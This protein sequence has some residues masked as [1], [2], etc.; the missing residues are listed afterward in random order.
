MPGLATGV[1]RKPSPSFSTLIGMGVTTA[2]CVAVGVGGGYWLDRTFR[3]GE[4][5]TFVGLA[6]GVAAAVAA[7]YLEIKTFL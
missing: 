1:S 5:L 6:L 2:L 3:T 4:L 7:V